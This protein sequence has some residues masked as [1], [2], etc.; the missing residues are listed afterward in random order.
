MTIGDEIAK[1]ANGN[2]TTTYGR[3]A[4]ID[5]SE[6]DVF[7]VP[8]DFRT[9]SWSPDPPG[10]KNA[11]VTQVHLTFRM[12]SLGRAMIRFK[13]PATLDALIDALVVHREDVFG[14]RLEP[15]GAGGSR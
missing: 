7:E 5:V 14:K 6:A 9:Y 10:T 1:A 15:W 3:S 12:P 8:T 2:V 4:A 13:G 11:K